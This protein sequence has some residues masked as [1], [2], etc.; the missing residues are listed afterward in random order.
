MYETLDE[1]V[2]AESAGASDLV[3]EN[4]RYIFLYYFL[5]CSLVSGA[6]LVHHMARFAKRKAKKLISL[7]VE[8]FKLPFTNS[9]RRSN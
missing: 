2:E 8:H 4:F 9:N 7:V 5:V 6:F 1:Y 3:I